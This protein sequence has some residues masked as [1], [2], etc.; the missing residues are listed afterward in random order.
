M[1][2]IKF[3]LDENIDKAVAEQLRRWNVDAVSVHDLELH[4]DDDPSHLERAA[5][6]GRVLCTHDKDFIVMAKDN[7]AHAGIAFA[8]HIQASVGGWVRA[9]RA[10]HAKTEA[11]AL[12]GVLIYL[13]LK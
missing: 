7:T 4:G 1:A 6:M 12:H 11:E 13:S 3:Y 5:G 10:L 9:L 8:P 2:E